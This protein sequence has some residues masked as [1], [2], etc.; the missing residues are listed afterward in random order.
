MADIWINVDAT[1]TVPLN[2]LPL[3]DDTDFKTI[4][5]AVSSSSVRM[6]WNFI[7]TAGSQ[8]QTYVEMGAAT[9]YKWINIGNGLYATTIPA[10]GGS[11]VNNDTEGFGWFSGSGTGILPFRSPM[12]GFRAAILNDNLIDS[13]NALATGSGLS[14]LATSLAGIPSFVWNYVTRTL[15]SR[16]SVTNS[17]ENDDIDC[18][19]GD[20]LILTF[21]DI[22]IE[23]GYKNVVLTVKNQ[24]KDED[25]ESVIQATSGCGL[26]YLNGELSTTGSGVTV[27]I[28][29]AEE[30]AIFEIEASITKDFPYKSDG[31]VYDLQITDALDDVVTPRLGAFNIIR[32]VT[33]RIT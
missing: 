9:N 1:V 7:P 5:P 30:K 6:Y 21:D 33:K 19:R 3:V 24:Y 29:V 2:I 18:I 4:E 26:L 15:T 16:R 13:S 14:G 20:T 12:I 25:S 23:V 22:P 10:S 32:D 31:F 28:D 11:Y 8:A 27:T 17:V